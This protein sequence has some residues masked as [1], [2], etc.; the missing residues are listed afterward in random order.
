M[1]S[2]TLVIV[3]SPTKARTIKKFLPSEY[4]VESCMGHLRD[5]PESAKA[6]P[7]E[8]KK[9]K[10]SKIGVNTEK[11]FE[12]LYC[13]P[14]S[15][16]KVVDNLI[17]KSKEVKE[18]ILATDEDR[19]GEGISWHLKEILSKKNPKLTFKRMVFHEITKEAILGA[20]KDFRQIN[21][22]LVRSQE[23]R[24]VL[25]R[26]VGYSISPVLWKN[27]TRGLSAGRVQSVAVRLLS[28]RE[29]KRMKFNKSHYQSITADL[30][31]GTTKFES[32]LLN[33]KGKNLVTS[34]DFDRETGEIKNK[35][36]LLLD[37]KKSI[38]LVS[39]LKSLKYQVSEVK[40]QSV[41]KKPPPPFT[42]STLQ[43]EANRKLALSSKDTM[44]FAQKL[45]ERGFIT[46][47]RTDSV[48]LSKQACSA[49]RKSIEKNYGKKY[50]PPTPRFYKTKSKG[51]QEAHE[52]IRPSGSTFVHPKDSKL[53][54]SLLQVYDIIWKRTLASQTVDCEQ[55]R[56]SV[57]IE[58]N[59]VAVFSASGMTI[60]F[61]GYYK[62]YQAGDAKD[63]SEKFL[64]NL[65][66]GDSLKC[67][68]LESKD[69]ETKPMA[70]FTEA[71]LIE[72]LEKEG[73][74]RPSTYTSIIGTIQKRGY[75]FKEQNS[76]IPTITALIVTKFLTQY[77]PDYVGIKF[78]S[79]MELALDEIAE[80]T[81]DY[82]G[83]LKQIYS[84]KKGLQNQVEMKNV[85]VDAK[86]SRSIEFENLKDYSFF[87]GPYG[88]YV[89]KNSKKKEKESVSLLPNA[90]PGDLTK[91]GIMT[92][93][94]Q[95]AKGND[96]L[97]SDPKTK[98]PIYVLT[99]RFGP[100]VQ[101]GDYGEDKKKEDIK[102]VSIPK[103]IETSDV[104]LKMAL[105]LL[106]LPKSIGENPANAKDIK[107]GIG[108]FGL[109]IVCDGDFR[110]IKSLDQFFS[111][112]LKE[113][114]QIL[115]EPKK[116]SKKTLKKIGEHPKLKKDIQLMDGKYGPYV[117]CGLKRASVPSSLD[118][119]KLTLAEAVKLLDDKGK[120][121]SK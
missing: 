16:T 48:F 5:L 52:A 80:G 56:V 62:I 22:D 11:N 121:K 58:A 72:L 103:G 59:S 15:K 46:Y 93:F 60:I 85:D 111:L 33:Y 21:Q 77:F 78:T 67:K 49:A 70:R 26:L 106:E 57:K 36:N 55:K 99:G 74:G 54:G 66:K 119:Q 4:I 37:S 64:P 61:D 43:Q 13:I 104:D 27:V 107:K 69:H 87:A 53:S 42:T 94:D 8:Y 102:R 30:F 51:A 75:V 41:S 14:S 120:K 81:K 63:S 10:W 115:S 25:D 31:K 7:A 114:I 38:S 29:L 112:T 88:A 24:R 1:K 97:G 39:E 32:K 2:K 91:E 19:E 95:K 35:K 96:S 113:A 47:M 28:E 101:R 84:G 116:G 17:K 50:L 118:T 45:Y 82:T 86:E 20:L 83:Y 100:Y 44:G 92:L 98:D 79:D 34:A 12:P 76:L 9:H 18:V 109:Y 40:T 105:K 89:T 71:S 108:R 68:S 3:E 90:C 110:S 23:A 73:I 6:I 117:Q 65:K